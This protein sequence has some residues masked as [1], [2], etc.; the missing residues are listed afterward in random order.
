MVLFFRKVSFTINTLFPPLRKTQYVGRVKLL[1]EAS[2]FFTHAVLQVLV[3]GK[4]AS[5]E[6]AHQAAKNMEVGRC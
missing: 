6:C 1:A 2:E 5:L 4:T 3:V